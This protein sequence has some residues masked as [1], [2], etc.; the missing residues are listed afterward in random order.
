M[1]LFLFNIVAA[2]CCEQTNSGQWCQQVEVSECKTNVRKAPTSCEQTDY[3]APGTCIDNNKGSCSSD[4]PLVVCQNNGGLWDARD[5]EDIPQ[6]RQ[7][8]CFYGEDTAFGTQVEC[9]QIGTDF[10]IETNWDSSIKDEFTC[11]SMGNQ[12]A[13]GACV[14][15][16]NTRTCLMTSKGDCATKG[17]VFAEGFYVLLL[18]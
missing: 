7:G 18:I 5:I 2:V 8:C 4:T 16:T 6:C 12:R 9:N 11:N 15:E 13:E 14:I 10:G 1:S 17:G 3:C